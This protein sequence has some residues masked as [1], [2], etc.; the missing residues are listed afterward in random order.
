MKMPV[1]ILESTIWRALYRERGGSHL[2]NVLILLIACSFH[3]ITH[4]FLFPDKAQMELS[5]TTSSFEV[6]GQYLHY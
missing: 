6:I 5:D 2:E 4:N 3:K 1:S